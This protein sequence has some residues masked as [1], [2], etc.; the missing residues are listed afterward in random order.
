[1]QVSKELR[2]LAATALVGRD[3]E[4]HSLGRAWRSARSGTGGVVIVHGEAGVGKTRLVAA[5]TELVRPDTAPGQLVDE[6][7]VG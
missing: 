7:H 1:M 3:R 6:E 5:L 2:R 4:P